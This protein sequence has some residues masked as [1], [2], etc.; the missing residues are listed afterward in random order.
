LASAVGVG[1]AAFNALFK[2]AGLP[3]GGA[4][5]LLCW[6]FW[7]AMVGLVGLALYLRGVGRAVFD[8]EQAGP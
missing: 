7:R 5:A 4:E 8:P 3:Q 1:E 6:R 2:L